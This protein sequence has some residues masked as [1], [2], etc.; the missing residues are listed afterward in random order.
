MNDAPKKKASTIIRDRSLSHPPA[1]TWWTRLAEH[2]P[3]VTFFIVII[4]PNALWSIANYLYNQ[5]LIVEQLCTEPAQQRAFLI[6]SM[7]YSG[8]TWIVGMGV[9]VWLIWPLHVYF[10][11]LKRSE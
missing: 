2:R 10:R 1:P 3:V 11:A 6:A 4:W 9:C 7:V 5:H 8:F